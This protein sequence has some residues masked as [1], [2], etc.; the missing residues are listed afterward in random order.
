MALMHMPDVMLLDEPRN[1]LDDDG[2]RLLNE[3]VVSSA[4][5]APRCCGAR[6]AARI[7]YSAS[8]RPTRLKDGRLKRIE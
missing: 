5:A 8:T 4:G 7:E 6:H 3:Q 2:Y 1:S